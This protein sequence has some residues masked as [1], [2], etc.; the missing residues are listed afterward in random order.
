M[1]KTIYISRKI[2]NKSGIS[3]YHQTVFATVLQLK[4]SNPDMYK[5]S[6]M[7]AKIFNDGCDRLSRFFQSIKHK[8]KAKCQTK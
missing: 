5:L 7:E 1:D 3:D 8:E 4:L 6:H 2:L